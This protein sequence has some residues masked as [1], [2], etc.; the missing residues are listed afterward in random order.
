MRGVLLAESGAVSGAV[1]GAGPAPAHPNPLEKFNN[2]V[3]QL[4][5]VIDPWI[6]ATGKR[7]WLVDF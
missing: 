6:D 5:A 7:A 4:T 2:E 3:A 1:S